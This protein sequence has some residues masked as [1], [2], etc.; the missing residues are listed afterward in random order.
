MKSIEQR[1]FVIDTLSFYGNYIRIHMHPQ[2]RI[3]G[4]TEHLN[5]AS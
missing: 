4:G 1:G 3:K 2:L 5:Y